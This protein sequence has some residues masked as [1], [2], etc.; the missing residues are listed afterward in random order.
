[1]K[2]KIEPR[3]LRDSYIMYP[4]KEDIGIERE[5]DREWL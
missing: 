3:C 2:R 1:M 5:V 4:T